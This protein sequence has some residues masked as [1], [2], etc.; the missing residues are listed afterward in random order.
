MPPK[1]KPYSLQVVHCARCPPCENHLCLKDESLRKKCRAATRR[2]DLKSHT[3][4]QH[5]GEVPW[6][7]GDDP[8]R[9]FQGFFKV[10][11]PFT[12]P[13]SAPASS[14]ETIFSSESFL[15]S[16][17]GL[18]SFHFRGETG[19][20]TLRSYQGLMDVAIST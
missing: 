4:T 13:H 11:S 7:Q 2:D 6:A 3:S 10:K 1:L 5:P 20:L 14:S 19:I 9:T 15:P 17:N 8:P 12:R 18:N 16:N